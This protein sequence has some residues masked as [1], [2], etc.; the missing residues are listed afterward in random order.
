MA[1]DA[2]EFVGTLIPVYWDVV[3]TS[4][5]TGQPI[6]VDGA[7][8]GQVTPWTFSM[9]EGTSALYAVVNPLYT[10]V[11]VDYQVT[12]I[13]A[14]DA[15]HFVGTVIP[16]APP[17]IVWPPDGV[18]NL[19]YGTVMLSW[20]VVDPPAGYYFYVYLDTVNPPLALFYEGTAMSVPA[21]LLLPDTDY[22]WYVKMTWPDTKGEISSEVFNFKTDP[23]LLPVELSSFTATV[24]SQLFVNLQWVTQTETSALGYNIYRSNTNDEATASKVNLSVIPA[25]NTSTQ[26]TYTFVDDT[27]GL[28]VNNTY[29]YWLE[30]VDFNGMADMH[31]PVNVTI[32]GNVTPILPEISVLNNA[33]P[34]PF[35][36]GGTANI[37]VRIKANETGT[38]TIYNLLGQAVKTY[39]KL[40]PGEHNLTWNAKGCASG[41]YFY[42]LSTSSTNVTK[43]LVIVN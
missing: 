4:V 3:V 17:V 27:E 8:S 18:E 19:P 12:A 6:N 24:T 9:L 31:G 10:W 1:D 29:Y 43:K 16:I 14:D 42:K 20:T 5:P 34:N 15:V 25:T 22:W 38:V 37:S 23:F 2:V 11:P 32:T 40:Q 33:Y 35:R 39:E 13:M 36:F 41:I 7:P 28:A 21:G 26:H 30:N